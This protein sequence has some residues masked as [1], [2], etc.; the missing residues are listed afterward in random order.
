MKK[1]NSELIHNITFT[2]KNQNLK[3]NTSNFQRRT[4]IS[5][6]R[7]AD[8]F[9]ILINSRESSPEKYAKIVRGD[10]QMNARFTMKSFPIPKY[11]EDAKSLFSLQDRAK[12]SLINDKSLLL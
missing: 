10:E 6:Y 9:P 12:K 2:F 11:H 8:A 3:R 7:A 4:L 1:S 5:S